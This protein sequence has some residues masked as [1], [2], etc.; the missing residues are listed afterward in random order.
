MTCF[1]PITKKVIISDTLVFSPHI[2][3]FLR[4]AASDIV[5]VLKTSQPIL[6]TSLQTGNHVSSGL[7]QLVTILK[8]NQINNI[9]TNSQHQ[10]K[11]SNQH[12]LLTS[13]QICHINHFI[14]TWQLAFKKLQSFPLQLK[15]KH[16]PTNSLPISTTANY[17]YNNDGK[18]I[19][20]D[21]LL[22]TDNKNW[23]QALSNEFGRLTQSNYKNIRCTDAMEFIHPSEI[24]SH[25]KIT[26]ASL[27]YDHQP[28]TPEK[29][30][31][32]LIIGS[33]K[34]PYYD[35]AGSPAANL[36][37]TKLLLNSVISQAHQGACLMD[38]LP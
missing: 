35:D 22:Q 6:P 21:H 33:D 26:Y 19:T 37:E 29:W 1:N 7:F 25:A 23:N 2:N 34:L 27:I 9:L 38:T 10:L 31:T 5:T 8:T 14:K 28:L 3:N 12:T 20:H 16:I 36:I 11:S 17:I 32:W 24:A 18:K 15:S 4:Q 13:K 30:R